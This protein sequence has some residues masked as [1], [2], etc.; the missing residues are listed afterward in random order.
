MIFCRTNVDC[1]NLE[2]F[3]KNAGDVGSDVPLS[4][5]NSTAKVRTVP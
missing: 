2:R 5:K 3:L 1:N 4:G